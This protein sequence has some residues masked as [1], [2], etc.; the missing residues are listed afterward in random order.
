MIKRC[1]A[2]LILIQKE[3]LD[4]GRIWVFQKVSEKCLFNKMN[5]DSMM[6]ISAC[7]AGPK[8]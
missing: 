6:S 2:W 8:H 3:P 4:N 1:K 7:Q 5:S